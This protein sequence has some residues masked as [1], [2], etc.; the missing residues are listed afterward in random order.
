[1][2]EIEEFVDERQS[3]DV[4]YKLYNANDD[5]ESY[6]VDWPS[7][8]PLWLRNDFHPLDPATLKRAYH[9]LWFADIDSARSHFKIGAIAYNDHNRSIMF[10][11]GRNRTM[12]L[13]TL[14]DRV[15][16]AIDD[17]ALLEVG[18]R[19]GLLQPIK[20]SDVLVLPELP[21]LTYGELTDQR[22]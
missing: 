21:I 19:K 13:S 2:G 16:L 8:E 6:W 17:T 22:S 4:Q 10:H 3:I 1:M 18:I 9:A 14:M 7:I 15:P 12:L 20:A 11:N 5:L